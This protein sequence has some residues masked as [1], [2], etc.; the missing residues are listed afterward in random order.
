MKLSGARI[1]S[2]GILQTTG[3]RPKGKMF[4]DETELLLRRSSSA[5]TGKGSA[6]MADMEKVIAWLT[7]ISLRPCD[8]TRD[9][10][11]AYETEHLAN[12]ALEICEDAKVFNQQRNDALALLKEQQEQIDK[13][14]E[15]SASNAEI[16]EGYA[17]LLKEQEAVEPYIDID[18]AKCP[19]YKV[20]LTRQELLG[21]NVL[22]EDFFDYCPHCG[23]KVK[24]Q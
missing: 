24:W 2:T 22:F 6:T 9:D 5:Q 23:R 7:E 21:D 10:F 18:E 4:A 14:L 13:L 19:I 16:A 8:F 11:D 15:E 17:E 1:A 20:K 3:F 12:E